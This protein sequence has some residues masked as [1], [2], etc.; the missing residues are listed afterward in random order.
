MRSVLNRYKPDD[1]PHGLDVI[2]AL[3][4]PDGWGVGTTTSGSRIVWARLDLKP[5]E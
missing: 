2:E 5:G 3:T 1:R 4:G